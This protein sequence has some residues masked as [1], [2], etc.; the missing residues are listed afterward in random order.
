MYMNS[1]CCLNIVSLYISV[2]RGLVV[3]RWKPT[4]SR[5]FLLSF[6]VLPL[7]NLVCHSLWPDSVIR[8]RTVLKGVKG[9]ARNKKPT[10]RGC[11]SEG[12]PEV[13]QSPKAKP[14]AKSKAK[15]AGKKK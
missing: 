6:I 5:S 4:R 8:P 3:H 14:K 13:V 9:K 10:P 2:R 7:N 12:E 1:L 15:A 11:E